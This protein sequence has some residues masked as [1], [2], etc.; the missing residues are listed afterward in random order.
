MVTILLKIANI[1]HAVQFT[2]WKD[3]VDHVWV[4][5]IG[6][7]VVHFKMITPLKNMKITDS[8]YK[9][10]QTGVHMVNTSVELSNSVKHK[11]KT[12][13]NVDICKQSIDTSRE[14]SQESHAIS[15]W[16]GSSKEKTTTN[17]YVSNTPL[18]K[19][20]SKVSQGHSK[21]TEFHN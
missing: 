9:P 3:T 21:A 15:H 6:N 11:D 12:Q 16:K 14:K 13:E 18:I 1:L 8:N 20:S 19:D 2:V 5:Q 17:N 7:K 10:N 4:Y